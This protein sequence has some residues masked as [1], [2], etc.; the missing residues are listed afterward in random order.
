MTSCRSAYYLIFPYILLLLLAMSLV[1]SPAFP[2]E[3][4]RINRAFTF[5]QDP[6]QIVGQ[7]CKNVSN[8]QELTD[9]VNFI[10]DQWPSKVILDA[11][12]TTH[13]AYQLS[14]YN[15][16]RKAIL[17]DEQHLLTNSSLMGMLKECK[18]DTD[19]EKVNGCYDLAYRTNHPYIYPV[20]P[21]P[22]P[23]SAYTLNF[24]WVNLN[25]QDRIQDAAQHIFGD[26]LDSSV[27]ACFFD[28]ISRWADLHPGA[29][30][31]LWYD[32]ALVTRK[33]QQKA[34]AMT[35]S[36]SVSKGVDLRLKDIRQLPNIE[37]E[38]EHSL[39]PGTNVYYRVDILKALIVDHLMALEKSNRYSIVADLDIEPM[40]PQQ[41]FDQR[42]LS[43]LGMYGY[44]FIH[45][46]QNDF[47]NGFFIFDK[48][49]EGLQRVHNETIIQSIASIISAQRHNNSSNA[50]A[51]PSLDAQS[52]YNLYRHFH[53]SMGERPPNLPRKVVI[54]SPSQFGLSKNFLPSDYR[55][56]T[57]RFI[58]D[59]PTPYTQNGRNYLEGEGQIKGLKDWKAK[60]LPL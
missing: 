48:Q 6:Q 43:F 16:I 26:G 4:F 41:I 7:L 42:T 57:F 11:I 50:L 31:H 49:K 60:P 36:I 40:L 38:I 39:H 35:K 5:S 56:E 9:L 30:M 13:P 45:I 29:Q 15:R 52:V 17:E 19:E 53:L 23:T 55:A 37:G 14:S 2:K 51:S 44:V 34:F 47:E 58:G 3:F 20:S 8:D 18:L 10:F 12:L 27:N 28:Q 54:Y 1:R 59:S 22:V 32:S 33:A 24:L 25:P 46:G 21:T